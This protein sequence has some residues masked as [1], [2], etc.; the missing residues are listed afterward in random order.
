MGVRL[1][2]GQRIERGGDGIRSFGEDDRAVLEQGAAVDERVGDGCGVQLGPLLDVFAELS[3]LSAQRVG[4]PGRDHPGHDARRLRHRHR[5]VIGSLLQHSVRIG[6]ADAERRDTGPARLSRAGPGRLLGQQGDGSG[7]PVD[8][9]RG[10][11]DVQRLRQHAVLQ[12]HDHLDEARDTRSGLGVADV[13]LHRAQ[14]QGPVGRAVLAVRGDQCLGLD[15]VAQLGAGAVRLDGVDLIGGE[16]RVGEGLPDDPLLRG[17]VGGGEAVAG[18]VLVHRRTADDGKDSVAVAACVRQPL[19]KQHAHALG[20]A[21]AVGVGREGPAPAVHGQAALPA[22][23]GEG[24]GHRH[25][26]HTAGQRQRGLALPQRLRREMEGDQRRRAARVQGDRGALQAEDVRD[27]ARGDARRVARTEVALDLLRGLAEARAVVVVADARE[28]GRTTAPQGLGVDAGPLEGLPGGLQQQAL[29]RVH[30]QGLA[31]R[32]A[33]ERGVEVG[34]VVQESAVPGVGLAALLRV[35]VIERVEVPAAVG[36]QA[37]DHVAAAQQEFPQL[38]G[39]AHA[40]R[41]AAPHADDDDRVVVGGRQG[42]RRHGGPGR[43]GVRQRSEELVP[44]MGGEHTGGG[45]V[46]DE[47]RRQPQPGGRVESVAQL[48]RGQR[49][50]AQITEHPPRLDRL[51]GGMTEDRGR[52]VAHQ[53]QQHPVPLLGRETLEP[54]AQRRRRSARRVRARRGSGGRRG[55]L[56]LAL[57]LG[58][59]REQRAR[60]RR[61]EDRDEALPVHLGHGHEGLVVREDLAHRGEG[62]VRVEERQ[63]PRLQLLRLDALRQPLR[64]P[65]VPHAPCDGTGLQTAGTALLR[66]RVQIGVGGGVGA[67]VTAAPDTGDGGEQHERVEVVAAQQLVQVSGARHL[68]GQHVRELVEPRLRQRR[69]L[70]ERRRVYDRTQGLPVGLQLLQHARE[71]LAVGGVARGHRE[72]DPLGGQF[73]RQLGHARSG[74]AAPAGQHHMLGAV[75]SEPPRDVRAER[76]RPAGHQRRATGAPAGRRLLGRPHVQRVAHQAPGEDDR[77]ADRHLVLARQPGQHRAQACPGPV[78]QLARQIDEAAPALGLLQRDDPAQAP[79]LRLRRTGHGVGRP[80]RHRPARAEPHRHLKARVTERLHESERSCHTGRHGGMRGM[81]ALVERQEGEHA[82]ER[83]VLRGQLL[84]D[85]IDVRPPAGRGGVQLQ[86]HDL[87]AVPRQPLRRRTDDVVGGPPLREHH[88]PGP[89][90]PGRGTLVGHRLPADPVPPVVHRGLAPALLPPGRERGQH[91]AE[92]GVVGHGE[93]VGERLPVLVLHGL[94][95]A[96]VDDVG[97][98]DGGVR[99]RGVRYVDPVA[100]VLEGVG[101][102]VDVPTALADGPVDGVAVGVEVCCRGEEAGEGAFASAEAAGG[103]RPVSGFFDAVGEDGVGAGLD[104]GGVAGLCELLDGGVEVDG[105]AEVAVPVA[106]VERLGVQE[107][108]FDGGE[109]GDVGRARLDSRKRMGQLGFD[110]LDVCGV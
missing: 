75:R 30:R 58:N 67:V 87:R 63:S 26:G 23:L 103:D 7:R 80:D 4:G 66:E 44:Q 76:S 91:R 21:H 40:A 32:D 65:D 22:E 14:P 84:A 49:V 18:A 81:G 34:G 90:E 38:L 74:R 83:R 60:S 24:G 93:R 59:T 33:E 68:R 17:A 57:R 101:G 86:R 96:R 2:S 55:R 53:L 106:G 72:T 48:N 95:E 13:G 41:E 77:V 73:R 70:D 15:G 16:T 104:V 37:R 46:E 20:H 82:G 61:G 94:P 85:E 36:R 42:R 98:R 8:L 102:Q 27:A 52:L 29:L 35:R 51:T 97:R 9:R 69:Q 100:L 88:E 1:P 99:R 110:G 107:A 39:R 62:R 19:Q 105:L 47:G 10:L 12:R 11:A 56:D 6:A 25:H 5:L 54:V 64:V 109:E 28:H 43:R 89:P 71:G 108:G 45:V 50:E 92:R 78:V 79:D 31:R 3:C